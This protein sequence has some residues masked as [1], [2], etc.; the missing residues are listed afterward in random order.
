MAAYYSDTVNLSAGDH[1]ISHLKGARARVVQFVVNGVA[2]QL[3]W[4]VAPN[5]NNEIIVTGPEGGLNDVK[6]NIIC[7]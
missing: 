3:A 2:E 6:I 7:Y 1:T 4:R 5:A